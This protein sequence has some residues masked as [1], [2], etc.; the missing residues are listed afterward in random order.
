MY[1]WSRFKSDNNEILKQVQKETYWTLVPFLFSS[2][3]HRYRWSARYIGVD[4]EF[5]KSIDATDRFDHRSLQGAYEKIAAYYRYKYQDHDGQLVL[6]FTI[7]DQPNFNTGEALHEYYKREW[8]DYW[9][10]EIRYLA[11]EP[12]IARAVLTATVYDN[13]GEGYEAEELLIELLH[14]RYG[15]E[16]DIEVYNNR[17]KRRQERIKNMQTPQNYKDNDPWE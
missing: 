8:C 6:P 10:K 1:P 16:W 15:K 11:T 14:N 13:T 7:P 4:N 12:I 3:R 2:V 5:S 17:K 9:Y